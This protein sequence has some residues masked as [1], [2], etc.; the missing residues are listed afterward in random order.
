MGGVAEQLDSSGK[1]STRVVTTSDPSTLTL[2]TNASNNRASVDVTVGNWD[3]S[4]SATFHLGG[5]T[6][7]NNASSAFI[8]NNNYAVRD[9]T[10]TK[11]HHGDRG[12]RLRTSPRTPTMV[13]YNVVTA[14]NPFSSA[15]VYALRFAFLPGAGWGGDI[16]YS[17]ARLQ[18]GAAIASIS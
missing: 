14:A 1:F 16:G 15:D 9:R 6:G 2:N 4:T 18:S 11:K 7:G 8:D 5:T 12:L 13:S 10:T 3:T 17:T